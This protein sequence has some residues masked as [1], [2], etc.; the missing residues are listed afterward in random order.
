M[1]EETGATVREIRDLEEQVM[2]N[3]LGF[4]CDVE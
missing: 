4:M 2:L 3:I 1:V